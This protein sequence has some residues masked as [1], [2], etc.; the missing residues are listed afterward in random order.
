M[1]FDP[2]NLG[3][4][5]DE[6]LCLLVRSGNGAAQAEEMLVRRFNRLVRAFDRPLFLAGGDSVSPGPGDDREAGRADEGDPRPDVCARCLEEAG[7]LAA[8]E[9]RGPRGGHFC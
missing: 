6:E 7:P 1:N 9:R 4:L 8:R 2:N 5:C 3:N